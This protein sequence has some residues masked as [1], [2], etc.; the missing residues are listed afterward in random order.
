MTDV[1]KK[2]FWK[3]TGIYLGFVNDVPAIE[4]RDELPILDGPRQPLNVVNLTGTET[5]VSSERA[6]SLA[7]V[8]RAVSIVG[9]AVS[10]LPIGVWRNGEE[11]PLSTSHLVVRPN[12]ELPLHAFLEQTAISLAVNGNAYWLLKRTGPIANVEGIEVLNPNSV[13]IDY[14]NGRKVYRYGEKTFPEW[15][16]K[17][18]MLTRLPGHEYGTGP[19]QA[20]Q[21]E[22]RGA[23]NLRNYA[24]E[25]FGGGGLPKG[26]LKTDKPLTSAKADE[27]NDR[28]DAVLAG[29]YRNLVLGDGVDYEPLLITPEQAQFLE[30]QSFSITQ[31]ARMFGVP[32]VYMMTD[33]GNS[34]TYANQEQVDAAFLRYTLIKYLV[35]I[36]AAFADLLP[37]GQVARFKTDALLRTDQSTRFASYSA[38]ISGGW[39]TVDE[40]RAKEGL[41]PLGEQPTPEDG[42]GN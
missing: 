24:D 5:G 17:H 7:A 13:V 15:R 2:G 25:W 22:L 14:D 35:E 20:A 42:V 3:K 41:L 26:K 1:D 18:L 12:L 31:I 37:R 19:I 33:P 30:S 21:N 4:V 40:V 6:L 8:Y 11:L 38:A 16:I 39:M 10:Q 27:Y 9:T 23:L 34:M 29:G 36:E 32:A 28:L